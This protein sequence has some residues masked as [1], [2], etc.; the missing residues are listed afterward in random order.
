MELRAWRLL[1]GTYRVAGHGVAGRMYL[2]A[3]IAT[4]KEEAHPQKGLAVNVPAG[5]RPLSGSERT[6]P[7]GARRAGPADPAEQVTVRVIVRRRTGAPAD[8]AV[9][10]YL[11]TAPMQRQALSV[12]EHAQRFG[13]AGSDLDGVRAFLRSGGL[14]ID[15]T[16][17]ASRTVMATGTVA[18]LNDLFGVTLGRYE[19]PLPPTRKRRPEPRGTQSYRS[20]DGPVHLPAVLAD[21]VVGVFGL[22]NRR[23]ARP[24]GAGDP[25][26][27]ETTTVPQVMNRYNFPL[28][29]A[30]GQTVGIFAT[31]GDYNVDYFQGIGYAQSD[32]DAYYADPALA[33]FTAP[34]LVPVQDIDGTANNPANPDSEATQDICIASTVAQGAAIAVYFNEANEN[35]WLAVLKKATFPGAADPRP[36]VLS[37][38]F[39]VCDGDDP[40]GRD[41]IPTSFL[42]A[43]SLA[44]QDA[45]AQ[46]LTVCVASGDAGSDS[47]VGDGSQHVQYPASDPWV[48][49]CGGTTI[50]VNKRHQSVEYVW[51]D[52]Q[53]ATLDD[54]TTSTWPGATGG[55]VSAYFAQPAYQAGAGVP[56][57]LVDRHI[58]RGV[59][60]VAANGSY[61][62][63][64]YPMYTIGNDPNPYPG[65]GT[66][67]AAPLYAGLFAVINAALGK[68][69]GF[70]NPVLYVFRN[71]VCADI[72]P[73]VA[74]GPANNS[75]TDPLFHNYSPGYPAGAGWDACTGWGTINGWALLN[76]LQ[77]LGPIVPCAI[78][79]L[80]EDDN[81]AVEE[82]RQVRDEQLTAPA[83]AFLSAVLV[84][85]S[86]DLTGILAD[87]AELRDESRELLR[88]AARTAQEGARFDDELVSRAER[89]VSRAEALIPGSMSG[90]AGLMQTILAS[91]RGRTL[92]DGI[93]K[94][95]ETVTPRAISHEQAGR[96]PPS[97]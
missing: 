80:F 90:I 94:A 74:G 97:S 70:I 82:M 28:S 54:G 17:A 91:L 21:V 47:Y 48:L 79:E 37:S 22:D 52:I 88:Q 58:G 3:S 75:F 11:T 42:D 81:A 67:A 12:E 68:R 10:A 25:T 84:Q 73:A 19:A 13:A 1:P 66:S 16:H 44:F 60:D 69:V 55:G 43:V 8:S 77:A 53:T 29:K 20:H 14:T 5:Y 31:Y 89:L 93:A 7:S 51:N 9:E 26:F 45:G 35:G 18:Q 4:P 24:N 95:S 2:A 46:G 39:Y 49:S 36:S 64:Y 41:G 63:G 6:Q 23:I 33:G 76:T 62:S 78:T 86:A 96:L 34:V 65:N 50:G 92:A 61:D 30:A 38:S 72:N 57:S 59:P 15:E 85:H 71:S 83:G 56:R 32:I 27:T 40:L 87:H